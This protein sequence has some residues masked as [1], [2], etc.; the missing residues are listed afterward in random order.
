MKGKTAGAG[1]QDKLKQGPQHRLEM[2]GT[3]QDTASPLLGS[4]PWG[5]GKW[6]FNRELGFLIGVCQKFA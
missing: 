4:Q 6:P 2:H 5:N 3:Y 1:L